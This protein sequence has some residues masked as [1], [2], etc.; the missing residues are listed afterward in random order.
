MNDRTLIFSLAGL[1]LAL[2]VVSLAIGPARL[3]LGEIW[4]GLAQGDGF[5][6]LVVREIR[7]PRAVLSLA[8]GGGLGLAGAGLQ[9]LL[10]NP[11]AEP[12][13]FGA[14]QAA[15]L[16]AV[17][18]LYFGGAGPTSFAV[19][20]AAVTGAVVALFLLVALA[21]RSESLSAFLLAGL[22]VASLAGALTTLALNLAPNPFALAEIVTWLMGSLENASLRHLWLALP[23]IALGGALL[24]ASGGRLRALALGEDVAASLGVELGG[25]RLVVVSG[26]ALIV[27]GATAA[28]GAIGFVGLVAPHLVRRFVGHDPGRALLPSALAGAALLTAA[29]I[30]VRLIPANTELKLGVL[31]SLIGVPVFLSI[32][33]AGQRGQ[34]LP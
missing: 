33:L 29:D 16:A 18:V 11:L 17:T 23:P 22:A 26:A 30:G 34:D 15:A 12:S 20:I 9:G 27:G 10:R 31:T 1:V 7:L 3:G 2:A 8:I 4:S 24:I 28:A 13:V 19:G 21:G 14:P 6:G 32:L 5:A 25:L